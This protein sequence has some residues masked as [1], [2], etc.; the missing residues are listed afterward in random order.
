[1][2]N[3]DNI[4]GTI[5]SCND[6]KDINLLEYIEKKAEKNDDKAKKQ[7][8][9]IIDDYKQNRYQTDYWNT[10]NNI[11]VLLHTL[12]ID[13]ICST[14]LSSK[15]PST[16]SIFQDLCNYYMYKNGFLNKIHIDNN[17]DIGIPA[18]NSIK[19][20]FSKEP[21]NAVRFIA[22]YSEQTDTNIKKIIFSVSEKLIEQ[23]QEI[24]NNTEKSSKENLFKLSNQNNL[25]KI[26]NSV[27]TIRGAI[28]PIILDEIAKLKDKLKDKN[29]ENNRENII[30]NGNLNYL[31]DLIDRNNK[32]TK[33]INIYESTKKTMQQ[34]D[35]KSTKILTNSIVGMQK[36][37]KFAQN[38]NNKK[39]QRVLEEQKK[40]QELEE[41]KKQQELEEQKKRENTYNKL[42]KNI[43]KS[44][45][46]EF[47]KKLNDKIDKFI[48]KIEK[49]KNFYQSFI[50][51]ISK[52]NKN[53]DSLKEVFAKIND[54]L[55]EENITE[56][57]KNTNAYLQEMTQKYKNE[58][59][60]EQKLT[61][62]DSNQLKYIEPDY[63]IGERK[64]REAMDELK[65]ETIDNQEWQKKDKELENIER[66]KKSIFAQ[67]RENREILNI[68]D[69]K[70]FFKTNN[71][72]KCIFTTQLKTIEENQNNK[73]IPEEKKKLIKQ[74]L[75][76]KIKINQK[77][78]KY[79]KINVKTKD[80]KK[81]KEP[82]LKYGRWIYKPKIK[83]KDNKIRQINKEIK[84]LLKLKYNQEK[85]NLQ[86]RGKYL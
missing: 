26:K 6:I 2:P 49:A 45:N 81:S 18:K 61:N 47:T 55:S 34:I 16:T 19:R 48:K 29:I 73:P 22:G 70:T 43:H 78:K 57:V 1:M 82:L 54:I 41:Q 30:D 69:R 17:K 4:I 77:K 86:K 56:V 38:I 35:S 24:A 15:R 44:K 23:L 32:I 20:I 83:R 76:Q 46:N 85:Q 5:K 3:Y 13:D 21:F 60:I 64:I 75:N 10:N 8:K 14:I 58:Q 80:N 33:I 62:D 59:I 79:N 12:T 40:Q 9:K 72:H 53:I 28:R 74:F 63:F 36:V 31:K 68:N 42:I 65:Y 39:K 52:N 27:F 11:D 71:N 67:A 7:L 50:E 37:L 25:E 84:N 66:Y 51:K